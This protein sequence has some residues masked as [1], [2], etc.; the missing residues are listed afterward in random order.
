LLPVVQA[1]DVVLIYKLLVRLAWQR[2]KADA[3]HV[4][5]LK[6]RREVAVLTTAL[7]TLSARLHKAM[8]AAGAADETMHTQEA[9]LKVLRDFVRALLHELASRAAPQPFPSGWFVQPDRPCL[10]EV[11]SLWNQAVGFHPAGR[12]E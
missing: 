10:Y 1:K 9:E 6:L 11:M 8:K 4:E 3:R 5:I 7:N 2:R 12:L